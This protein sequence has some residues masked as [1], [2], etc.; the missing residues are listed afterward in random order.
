M[1]L[2]TAWFVFLVSLLSLVACQSGDSTATEGESPSSTAAKPADP[3]KPI[4]IGF[5]VK[6]RADSWF[7]TELRFA[8]EAAKENGF[9]LIEMEGK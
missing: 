2:V 7:A 4:K 9:E 6:S 5:I 8:Q 3:S 1:R